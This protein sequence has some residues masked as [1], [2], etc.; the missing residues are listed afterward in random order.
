MLP[1]S[2]Q[3]FCRIIDNF[4]DAGVT[5]RVARRF[6]EEGVTPQLI[7]DRLDVM[8][9]L[10]PSLD[11]TEPRSTLD[12][13]CITDWDAFATAPDEP[14]D[15]VLETFGCRLPESFEKR[16][17]ETPPKLTLN[18]DYLSAEDWVESCHKMWGLHPTLPIRKLWYFPGFTDRT[19][20]VSI[21]SDYETK[22]QTFDRKA[23]LANLGFTEP[24]RPTLYFFLYPVNDV[25]T[26]AKTLAERTEP[27]NL[28]FA[29]GEGT[30]KLLTLLNEHPHPHQTIRAPFVAQPKFDHFLWAADGVVIRGEDSFV[31]AQ[32]AGV[33]LFWATYPTEDRAHEVKFEAWAGRVNEKLH[34]ECVAKHLA[35]NRAWLEGKAST[36]DLL[37]WL[38]DLSTLRSVFAPWRTGF[39]QRS[40]LIDGI[41]RTYEEVTNGKSNA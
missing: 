21:E 15:L 27:M 19:G 3:I 32:L 41:L 13:I 7:S 30:E 22:R 5:L 23:F 9:K 10:L 2:V 31:R 35:A 36:Q 14:A 34:N 29:P 18:L 26:W 6:L 25:E 33:P 16:L 40:E 4:G 28:L 38:D 17:A 8:A 20:G 12:G 11:P 1:R 37:E 39:F 24:E